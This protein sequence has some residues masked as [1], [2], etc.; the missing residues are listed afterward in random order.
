MNWKMLA[1]AGLCGVFAATSAAAQEPTWSGAII[2]RGEDR[3]RIEATPI[4]DRP[5]RPLHVYGNTVRREYY[6]GRAVPLPRD[7]LRGTQ[8]W[9]FR[10]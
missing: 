8:A 4:L 5:Y 1:I 6:R 7:V 2:E 10:R 3:A 9:V